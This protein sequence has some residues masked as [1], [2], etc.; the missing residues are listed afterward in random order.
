MLELVEADGEVR[1]RSQLLS[2]IWG[3]DH[4]TGTNVVEVQVARLR[5]KIDRNM[6]P[7]IHTVAG[8]GYQLRPAE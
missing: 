1:S 6:S 2:K 3:I 8:E 5:R 7:L 4:D